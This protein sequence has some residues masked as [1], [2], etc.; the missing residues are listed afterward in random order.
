MRG[1]S[2]F[3]YIL[4]RIEDNADFKFGGVFQYFSV[5]SFSMLLLVQTDAPG[6]IYL[7]WLFFFIFIPFLNILDALDFF[8][9]YF[10]MFDRF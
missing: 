8:I 4:C 6:T 9:Y 5:F 7:F 1:V 2:I 3:P 10:G